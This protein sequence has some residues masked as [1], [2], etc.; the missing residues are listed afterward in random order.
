VTESPSASDSPIEAQPADP[1]APPEVGAS[2]QWVAAS[3]PEPSGS[4]EPETAIVPPARSF[5]PP[6]PFDPEPSEPASA[7]SVSTAADR[8][9]LIIGGAFAGGL[10][11]GLILKRIAS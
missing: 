3:S 4:S 6:R 11:L 7:G 8:P 10:V 9:E 1:P 2:E 5:E